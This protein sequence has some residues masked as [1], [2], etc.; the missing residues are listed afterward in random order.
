VSI[1]NLEGKHL[2]LGEGKNEE[3]RR[4][5]NLG[6]GETGSMSV[7]VGGKQVN[8]EG[9]GRGEEGNPELKRTAPAS[10]QQKSRVIKRKEHQ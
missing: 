3:E 6:G 8:G 7:I 10:P 9:V 4:E 5:G 1:L 2:E